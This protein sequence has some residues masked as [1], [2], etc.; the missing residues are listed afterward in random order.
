MNE[1]TRTKVIGWLFQKKRKNS[2][3]NNR[4]LYLKISPTKIPLHEQHFISH[5]F[6]S[7]CATVEG[8]IAIEFVLNTHLLNGYTLGIR[9]KIALQQ[10]KDVNDERDRAISINV[11]VTLSNL[12]AS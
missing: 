3:L 8:V 5:R 9:N 10:K 4:D 2:N 1:C 6:G 7:L 12:T 11:T